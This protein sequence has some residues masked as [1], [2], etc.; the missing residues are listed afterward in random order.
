[1]KN[2]LIIDDV[3]DQAEGLSKALSK[4][5][6]N[7]SFEFKY[8]EDE[9]LDAVE[10]RFYTLAIVDIRMDEYKFDGID[11]VYKIL[12]V[13]PFAKIII[14]SAFKDEYVI[15]LKQ[16]LLSGKI[17]D[18]QD[19]ESFETWIPKLKETIEKYYDEYYNDP[20]EV[21]NALL[22]FYS[23][24][25]NEKDVYKKGERFEHFIS[26]IFQS[27]GYKQILKRVKDKS[28]NEVDLI[29]RNDIEDN[30]LEKFGKYILIECKNKPEDKVNKN[31][32]IVFQN[33]LKNTHGLAELGIIATTGHITRNT[34]LEAIRESG[35]LKKVLFLSNPEIEKFIKADDKK[36]FFKNLIDSQVKDN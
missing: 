11:L 1:M 4:A 31:D 7:Y 18:I 10:N 34:Y 12:E 19:K 3:K 26:L 9:I 6:P 35:G 16:I 29:V 36:I 21:N 24:A 23:D 27:I 2:I 5:L 15:K 13:N 30:F 20:S 8:T 32:F 14:V 28:L 17:L 33:K 22:Q 25:K